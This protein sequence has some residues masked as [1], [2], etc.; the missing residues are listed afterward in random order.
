MRHRLAPLAW[1][2]AASA[3]LFVSAGCAHRALAQGDLEKTPWATTMVYP[4]GDPQD[5]GKP[6]P[7]DHNGFVLS[8]GLVAGNKRHR[9]E[10]LDLANHVSGGEIR[11]VAPGLVVCTRSH[12]NGWGNMVVLAH[13]M[14]GGDILFSLFAH[15]LPGSI[16][17]REGEIV[18]LGQP[19]GRVGRTGHATGPHLHLEFR[20]IASSFEAMKQPLATAWERA[21]VVDPLRIFAAMRGHA[22]SLATAA[23]ADPGAIASAVGTA[24]PP[25]SPEAP[26]ADAF[27]LAVDGGALP[28]AV[29]DHGDEALTRGEL[30]R[31]AYA[32][33]APTGASVPN[34][35]STLRAMLLA[36][37]GALPK[38]ARAAFAPAR[39]PRR[40]SDAEAPASLVEMSDVCAALA[41]A[42]AA[43]GSV[44]RP[45]PSAPTREALLAAFPQGLLALHPDE[46]PVAAGPLSRRLVGPP[47]VSRRQACLLFAFA[48][49]G[50]SADEPLVGADTR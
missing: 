45:D 14:P 13:R 20:T 31:L 47:A 2:F 27:G 42:R 5:F 29:R 15:M 39:L 6:G 25:P 3:T 50:K 11:A 37:V 16:S 18:A 43:R 28:Q 9:H 17:V 4:V 1:L 12:S 23:P 26:V 34:R 41:T 10:G 38:E 40:T 19:L 24:L 21:S 49:A 30:Y 32:E 22:G 44:A 8:R 48:R 33:L 46:R 36:R 7:G 35:W